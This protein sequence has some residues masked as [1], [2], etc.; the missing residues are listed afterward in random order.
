MLGA[1]S[2]QGVLAAPDAPVIDEGTRVSDFHRVNAVDPLTAEERRQLQRGHVIAPEV[3][4]FDD[5]SRA[6]LAICDGATMIPEELPVEDDRYIKKG[7]KFD[8]L[9]ELRFFLRTTR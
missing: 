8:S 5:L 3:C 6:D 1:V 9:Q 7:M 4:P 2:A